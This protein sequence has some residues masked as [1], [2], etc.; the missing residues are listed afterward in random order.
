MQ[1][2]GGEAGM[3]SGLCRRGAAFVSI[4]DLE[5]VLDLHAGS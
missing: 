5:R 1:P 2:A 4:I 3:V